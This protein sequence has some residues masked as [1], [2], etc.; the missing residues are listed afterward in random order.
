MILDRYRKLYGKKVCVLC[1]DGKIVNGVWEEYFSKEDNEWRTEE[2]L[3]AS[4]TIIIATIPEDIPI[5]IE[6][7]SIKSITEFASE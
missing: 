7:T 4:E 2:G 3:S 5:E 6:S 1:S